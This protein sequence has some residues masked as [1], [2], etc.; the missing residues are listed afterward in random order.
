[1]KKIEI[2]VKKDG[3]MTVK[4]QGWYGAICKMKTAFLDKYFGK[5]TETEDTDEMHMVETDTEQEYN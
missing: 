5:D 4:P 1:M 3:G 2:I